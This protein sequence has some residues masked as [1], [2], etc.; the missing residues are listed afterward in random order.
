M[1]CEASTLRVRGMSGMNNLLLYSKATV[2]VLEVH[3]NSKT[4]L[5]HNRVQLRRPSREMLAAMPAPE[6]SPSSL[7]PIIADLLLQ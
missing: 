7:A 1:V 3:L 6:L 4:A 2:C 5:D